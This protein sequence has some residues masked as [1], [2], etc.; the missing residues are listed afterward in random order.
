MPTNK[1]ENFCLCSADNI[2]SIE[3]IRTTKEA[4]RY[5]LL[6]P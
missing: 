4:S 2:R 6:Q 3:A 1:Y 5:L